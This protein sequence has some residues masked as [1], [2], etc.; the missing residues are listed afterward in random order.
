M[1]VPVLFLVYNRPDLTKKVLEKIATYR[2]ERLYIAADGPKDKA[3]EH[4]I[5]ATREAATNVSWSCKVKTLLRDKNLGCRKA[6]SDGVDW[7]F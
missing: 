1:K 3:G 6:V 4:L 7:F 5:D 2:P